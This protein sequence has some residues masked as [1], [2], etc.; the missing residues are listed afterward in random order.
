MCVFIY[1]IIAFIHLN[2]KF[3]CASLK[4]KSFLSS[5]SDEIAC[6]F[7]RTFYLFFLFLSLSLNTYIPYIE[8]TYI[9][10]NEGMNV[11]NILHNIILL[12]VFIDKT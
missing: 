5:L 3:V 1:N 6:I 11:H 8:N 7:V 12:N 9:D 10:D 2:V 4:I